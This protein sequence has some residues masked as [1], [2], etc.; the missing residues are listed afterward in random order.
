MAHNTPKSK[1]EKLRLLG[2]AKFD[3]I[4]SCL[5]QEP[6]ASV[7]EKRIASPA[8]RHAAQRLDMEKHGRSADQRRGNL[9]ITPLASLLVPKLILELIK[10][11]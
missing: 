6:Y 2:D 3:E 8:R 11:R 9:D 4:V 1:L 5:S 7:D 10:G